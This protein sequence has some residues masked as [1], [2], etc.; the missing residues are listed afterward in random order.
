MLMALDSIIWLDK[1][2]AHTALLYIANDV[3]YSI[4]KEITLWKLFI[5]WLLMYRYDMLAKSKHTYRF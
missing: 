3:I 4:N 5:C 2:S 1:Q